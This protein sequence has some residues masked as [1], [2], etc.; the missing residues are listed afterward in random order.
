MHGEFK[1]LKTA[2]ARATHGRLGAA[3]Q[4]GS[5]VA[6]AQ[7]DQGIKRSQPFNSDHPSIPAKVCGIYAQSLLVSAGGDAIHP[8]NA[9]FAW[10]EAAMARQPSCLSCSPQSRRTLV[11]A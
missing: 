3:Q 4:L 11:L 6:G 1:G 10:D 2:T 8:E 9:G 7:P 5:P